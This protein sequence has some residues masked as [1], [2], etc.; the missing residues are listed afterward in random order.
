MKIT[1]VGAGKLGA[2]TAFSILHQT[3]A[4][5]IVLL[6]IVTDLAKGQAMDLE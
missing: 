4:D 6:D 1:V 5:E 2:A 3:S